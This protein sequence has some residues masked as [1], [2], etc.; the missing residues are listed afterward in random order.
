MFRA[1][2]FRRPS[3]LILALAA[4]LA[5]CG[6]SSSSS[7]SNQVEPFKPNRIISFGDELSAILPD[8]RH[9][10]VNGLNPETRQ[11]DCRLNPTWNQQLANSFGMVYAQC[12]PDGLAI[13]QGK[14]FA[15]AGYRVADVSDKLEQFLANDHL[16]PKDLVTFLVGMNDVLEIYRQF[17]AQNRDSLIAE[18]KARGTRLANLVNRIANANGRVIISTIYDMGVTPFAL[19]EKENRTDVD[20][21]ALLDE[22]SQAFNTA[23]RVQLLNDGRYI[24]LVLA[25]ETVQQIARF[26][27]A[28]GLDNVSQGACR[29]NVSAQS[30]STDTLLSDVALTTWLWATD[31]LLTPGVQSRI[32]QTA[33][34]RAHNNPF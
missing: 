16:G 6:G 32:G 1:F 34:L 31:T 30:C 7:S 15:D 24:G 11:F 12:N 20:R 23:L 21:A 10:G 5:S 18:A 19:S 17:P 9:F 33:I 13:P 27:F 2:S 29:A 26:P 22:I 28:F 3:A 25:D 8:G 14:L 4:L